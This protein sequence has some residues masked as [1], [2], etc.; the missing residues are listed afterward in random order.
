MGKT[1]I[2]AY[3]TKP[4]VLILFAFDILAIHFLSADLLKKLFY[5]LIF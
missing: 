1:L 2:P 4:P 3:F 5:Q